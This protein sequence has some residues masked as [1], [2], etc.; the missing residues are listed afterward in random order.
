[1]SS[2]K[3][4]V[5][6]QCCSYDSQR[7]VLERSHHGGITIMPPRSE[8]PG[9]L[10]LMRERASVHKMYSPPRLRYSDNLIISPA[11]N[12][13]PETTEAFAAFPASMSP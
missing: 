1:L 11:L 10:P 12:P 3:V 9:P 6:C 4:P 2:A 7:T 13:V 5:T 8:L